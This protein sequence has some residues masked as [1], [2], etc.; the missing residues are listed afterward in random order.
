MP[1]DC[2]LLKEKG[3]RTAF[4]HTQPGAKRAFGLIDSLQSAADVSSQVVD[5]ARGSASMERP[6][7]ACL[8]TQMQTPPSALSWRCSLGRAS[9]D[10]L[11]QKDS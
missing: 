6:T 3:T 4:G 5:D 1:I 8:R 7:S 2:R 11:E 10:E 9:A